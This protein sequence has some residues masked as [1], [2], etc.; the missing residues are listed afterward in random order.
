MQELRFLLNWHFFGNQSQKGALLIPPILAR[1]TSR[2]AD[3]YSQVG[4]DQVQVGQ[5]RQVRQANF[6]SM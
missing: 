5:V 2:L 1:Q 6:I 4:Q 3:P